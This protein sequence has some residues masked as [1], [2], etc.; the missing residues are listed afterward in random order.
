MYPKLETKL[1]ADAIGLVERYHA[2]HT[3]WDGSPYVLHLYRVVDC[4]VEAGLVTTEA[5]VTALLH[6][7]VEDTPIGLNQVEAM[8]GTQIAENIDYLTQRPEELRSDYF[9]RC[10]SDSNHVVHAVKFADRIDN[11]TGLQ[12]CPSHLVAQSYPET[13]LYEVRNYFFPEAHKVAPALRVSLFDIYNK[14]AEHFKH[15]V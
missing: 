10:F 12:D 4:V 1:I 11:I 3:R 6:D 13:Y 15:G 8:F 14:I 7:L 2:E 5:I 9:N